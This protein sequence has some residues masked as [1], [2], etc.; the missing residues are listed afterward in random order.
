MTNNFTYEF[1]IYQLNEDEP[2]YQY[3]NSPELTPEFIE[4]LE[5]IDIDIT[6]SIYKVTKL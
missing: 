4:F 3:N 5:D 2:T 6:T 1:E